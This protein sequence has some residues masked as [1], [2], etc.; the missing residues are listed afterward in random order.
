MIFTDVQ[1]AQLDRIFELFVDFMGGLQKPPILSFD[2]PFKGGFG[3]SQGFGDN[4]K[5]YQTWGYAGHF[6]IDFITPW[7]TEI[8]AVDDG[9]IIRA[10]YNIYNGNFVEIEHD[11]GKSLYLHFK[12]LPLV[13]LGDK[14]KKRQA[15][16]YAGNTGIVYPKPTQK[17][18][19]SGT[20]LHFSIK[21]NGVEN[22]EYK[23]FIDPQ[24]YLKTN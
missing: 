16:G 5:L 19:K 21:I 22:A 6:G 14:V 17:K 10:G 11:W 4:P 3:Q 20:H 24:P 18:P 2:L 15:L 12:N 23:D 7:G 8:L 13:T 1:R 9:K